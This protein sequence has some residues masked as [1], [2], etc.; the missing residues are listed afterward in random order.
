MK[1]QALNG[2]DLALLRR[3]NNDAVLRVL[4]G[5]GPMTLTEIAKASGLSRHTVDLVLEELERQGWTEELAPERGMGRPARRYRFRA[6]AG[7]VL[8]IDVGHRSTR[9]LLADLDGTAV[10]S[11]VVEQDVPGTERLE[12]IRAAAVAFTSGH[13][14]AR[15]RA[16]CLGVPGI[17]DA[18]GRVRRCDLLPEWDGLDLGERAATWFGC[19]ALADNDANLAAV[20][21]HWR[22]A[23]Q[24]SGDFVHLLIG[25]RTGA[26]LMLDGRLYRGRTGAAGEIAALAV[27]GWDG[28]DRDSLGDGADLAEVFAAAARGEHAALERVDRFARTYATGAAAMV[29]TLNPDLL[30]I[31]GGISL[32]GETLAEPMRHHLEQLCTEVPPVRVSPLGTEAVALGAVQSALERCDRDLFE[33]PTMF[34]GPAPA[35]ERPSVT[36]G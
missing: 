19:P 17:V 15:V 11:R 21:E 4:R 14:G 12:A 31:G 9:Y 30:V 16:V 2:G 22:G 8:G 34:D 29:L 18:A 23:A 27:L 1:R 26:A 28:A 7:Y 24:D 36:S 20:A 10:D 6:D 5:S 32:A 13:D 33:F 3:L 25:H 35:A